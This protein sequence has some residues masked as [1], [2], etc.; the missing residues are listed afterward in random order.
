MITINQVGAEFV[1]AQL[2]DGIKEFKREQRKLMRKAA[3][4]MKRGVESKLLSGDPLHAASPLNR[5][6]SKGRT[7]GPLHR[8]IKAKTRLTSTGVE[9]FIEYNRRGFYGRFHETGI[10]KTMTRKTTTVAFIG[11]RFVTLKAGT[12]YTFNLPAR[13]VLALVS[14]AKEAQAVEIMG[15]SFGVFYRGGAGA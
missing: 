1:A 11:G 9:A 3:L 7:I 10:H 15:D 8:R 5:K 14:K 13:P 4:V 6:D 12:S 2:R